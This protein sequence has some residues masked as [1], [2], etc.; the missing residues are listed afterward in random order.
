MQ[1]LEFLKQRLGNRVDSEHVQALIRVVIGFFVTLY[2]FSP[3]FQQ[4]LNGPLEWMSAQFALS[5]FLVWSLLIVLAIIIWPEKSVIRRLLGM[6]ADLG[7]TTYAMMLGGEVGTPLIAVYLWVTMGNGFRYGERYLF[8]SAILSAI[9]FSTVLSFNPFWESHLIFSSSILIV[10]LVLPLYLA[11]LMRKLNDAIARANEANLAKSQFLANMSHELRTPLNG[12]IGMSDLLADTRLNEEQKG[13]AQAI[14]SSAHSLLGLIEKILDISKI[15]EGQLQVLQEDFD[16]HVLLSLTTA[17]FEPQAQKKGLELRIQVAPE[18]PYELQGDQ[19]HLRQVLINLIGNAIKFTDFGSVEIKVHP[20]STKISDLSIRFEI[21][22]TG[23]GIPEQTQERI[24]QKFTQADS[25]I[26][27]RYGGTGLGTTIARQLIE[28]M[29]GRIGLSSQ[30]GRGSTFWFEL[31]FQRQ[32]LSHRSQE[33]PSA[34]NLQLLLVTSDQ[35]ARSITPNLKDWGIYYDRVA[36]TDNATSLLLAAAKRGTPYQL[37]LIEQ[38][39]GGEDTGHNTF[40][41]SIRAQSLLKPLSLVLISSNNNNEQTADQV[42]HSDY[43][44]VLVTPID[45]KL[46]FNSIHAAQA[47]RLDLE[48]VVSLAEYYQRKG[49]VDQLQILVAEDNATNQKVIRGVLGRAGHRPVIADDGEKALD[50]LADDSFDFDLVVLDMNMPKV[51]GVEVLKAFRF[52]D[53]RATVPVIILTAN[54][55]PEA[56]TACMDA[57]ADAYLT[58]PVDARKLLDTIARFAPRANQYANG[59]PSKTG[60]K[61]ASRHQSI[62]LVDTEAL[63]R[64]TQLGNGVDFL[65]DVIEGFLHDGERILSDLQIAGEQGVTKD[66]CNTVHAL[67]GSASELG[68]SKLVQI[69]KETKKLKPGD[70]STS[71]PGTL[72]KLLNETFDLTRKELLKF[73]ADQQDAMIE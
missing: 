7:T 53:T 19:Q 43:S 52:M 61:K 2:V 36:T 30:E 29:D 63:L 64:L 24:F 25:S 47:G 27:R 69:C 55:T 66:F 50:L 32:V 38:G 51:S 16:L 37:A 67:Q 26:T 35:V 44:S 5:L 73:V 6:V 58:K 41:K 1:P 54:A 71:K 22:D 9:G 46:L 72:V 49:K 17:M 57:G 11:T 18:T 20:V 60:S 39:C 40:V 42:F 21:K 23:I 45:T 65:R 4:R 13:L 48:N 12:V 56:I 68:C 33:S 3:F 34:G 8:C 14:Q 31:P 15:E 62:V 10:I 59:R 28:L 70:F